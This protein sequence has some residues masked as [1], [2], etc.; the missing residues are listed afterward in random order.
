M[1]NTHHYL[2]G[3]WFRLGAGLVDFLLVL[4]ASVPLIILLRWAQAPPLIIVL[5]VNLVLMF[6]LTRFWVRRS[7][8]LGNWLFSHRVVD[9][10]TGS[11]ITFKQGMIRFLISLVSAVPLFLGYFWVIWDKEKRSWHDK[12]A[13]TVVLSDSSYVSDANDREYHP[14]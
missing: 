1:D 5:I 3:F 13:G 9:H 2:I 8:T 4:L 7:A 6:Y 12:V 11:N 14:S 10:R